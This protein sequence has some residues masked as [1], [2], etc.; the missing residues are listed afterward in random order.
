M[1]L[2]VVESGSHCWIICCIIGIWNCEFEVGHFEIEIYDCKL[3]KVGFG[4]QGGVQLGFKVV[5]VV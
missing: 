3:H 2:Y 1:L 5:N 4:I